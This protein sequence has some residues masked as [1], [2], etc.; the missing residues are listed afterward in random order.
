MTE[1]QIVGDVSHV[2]TAEM[3]SSTLCGETPHP[4]QQ[5]P[6]NASLEDLMCKY[7]QKWERNFMQLHANEEELNRQFIDISEY[8]KRIISIASEELTQTFGKGYG[9]TTLRN[10]RKFYLQFCDI[11]IQ[12]PL[13]AEFGYPRCPSRCPSR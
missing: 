10:Y 11:Q 7:K 3:S 8:G 9:E 6:I 2:A 5:H 1:N 4:L 12:Q 13:L